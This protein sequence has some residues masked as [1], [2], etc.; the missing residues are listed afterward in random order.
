MLG[1]LPWNWF[2]GCVK[3][4]WRGELCADGRATTTIHSSWTDNY[5]RC[6]PLS[7]RLPMSAIFFYFESFEIEFIMHESPRKWLT[8]ISLSSNFVTAI[9]GRARN[10]GNPLKVWR[11][12]CKCQSLRWQWFEEM[13]RTNIAKEQW[14]LSAIQQGETATLRPHLFSL[15]RDIKQSIEHSYR[16]HR[17]WK[18]HHRH[19]ISGTA[20]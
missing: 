9:V 20:A 11:H 13:E 12:K 14:T 10:R 17:S 5:M 8:S 3:N 6:K 4:D 15:V 2:V 7:L 18:L 16:K 1:A 19:S